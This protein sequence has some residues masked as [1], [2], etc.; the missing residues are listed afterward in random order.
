MKTLKQTLIHRA[1]TLALAG[2]GLVAGSS[3]AATDTANLT[4][5]A[6]IANQC[7]V[8]AASLALGGI[9]LVGTDGTMATLSGGNTVNIPW[10][11][12]NGTDA[13]LAFNLGA[14][15]TGTDRRMASAA[16]VLNTFEYQLK[17]GTTSAGTPLTDSPVALTGADGTN[18]TFAV[19]AGPV[20]SNA[21]RAA[22]PATDY[23]D[24]VLLTITF[25]P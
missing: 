3:F 9:T 16:N 15:T 1:A 24:T 20:D 22:K 11:C 23:T 4:V 18:Q 14:N 12:T 13:T 19:W 5:T 7:S 17:A 21:N 8:G 6:S 10:A 2:A 25:T